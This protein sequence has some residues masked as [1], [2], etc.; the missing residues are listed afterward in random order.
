[1]VERWEKLDTKTLSDHRIFKIRQDNC[2]SPRTGETHTFFILETGDWINV[3]PVT[4][5]GKVVFI[6]QYRHGTEAV[7]LEIPGGMAEDGDSTM[8]A[9]AR[10]ELLEETG[11]GADALLHIGS[12]DPNPAFLTNQCHTFLALGARRV[13][14][15]Q[16]D[17]AEDI[18][19]EEIDLS[20]VASLISSGRISHALVVAAFYHLERYGERHPEWLQSDR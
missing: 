14:Q 16:F 11:Y 1:M 3:I 15:P 13:G 20:R 18:Q 9:S 8:A 6:H 19:V 12:V 5:E 7:S 10:R 2:R 4:S 17:R